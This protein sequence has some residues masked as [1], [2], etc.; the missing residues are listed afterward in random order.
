MIQTDR[1]RLN[2]LQIR[3]QQSMTRPEML[4]VLELLKLEFEMAKTALVSCTQEDFARLQGEARAY[5]NLV[6]ILTRENKQPR[7]KDN[8]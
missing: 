2:E 6:K 7:S 5:L 4:D 8:A 3:M 1:N